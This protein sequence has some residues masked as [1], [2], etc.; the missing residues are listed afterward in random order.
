MVKLPGYLVKAV[1]PAPFGVHPASLSS[2]GLPD[3]EGYGEDYDFSEEQHRAT[4]NAETLEAWIQEWVLGLESHQDYLRKLGFERLY[5]LKGKGAW[6]SWIHEIESLLDT[7]PSGPEYSDIEMM[8]V[9]AGRKMKE[10]VTRNGYKTILAGSGASGLAAWLAYYQAKEA[11]YHFDLLVG[12]GWYGYAPRPGESNLLNVSNLPTCKMVASVLEAYGVWVGGENA[13]TLSALGAAQVD[14]FGNVNS[15]KIPGE[16]YLV[17]SGGANDNC[18]AREVVVVL[19]QSRGRFLEKVP[20]IT[21]PGDRVKTLVSNFGVFEKV[22]EDEELSLTAYYPNPKLATAEEKVREVK[23]HCGWDLK[24]APNVQEMAPPT[25]D[26][27]RIL[28][29]LDPRKLFLEP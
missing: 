23:A 6:D 8:S 17:G 25:L 14:K 7:I 5:F 4:L 12:S 9:A 3:L 15:T 1:C 27:L 16:T 28:R 13:R 11:G 21:C 26:E 24:V 29:L 18:N 19:R 20:Y 2:H 10:K 22:G